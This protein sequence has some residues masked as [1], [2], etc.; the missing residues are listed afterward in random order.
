MKEPNGFIVG[1]HTFVSLEE[2]PSH[3]IRSVWPNPTHPES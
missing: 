1:F 2:P 3:R